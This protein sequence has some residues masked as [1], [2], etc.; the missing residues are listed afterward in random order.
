MSRLL[1]EVGLA[2]LASTHVAG[3]VLLLTPLH[4]K[5]ARVRFVARFRSRPRDERISAQIRKSVRK[6]GALPVLGRP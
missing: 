6:L 3:E 2:A 4:R 5:L 1:G